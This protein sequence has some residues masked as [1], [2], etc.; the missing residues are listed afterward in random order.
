MKK[1]FY[2]MGFALMTVMALTLTS[3]GDDDDDLSNTTTTKEL[4]AV[5]KIKITVTGQ[6]DKF[7]W[8]AT[9]RG[10]VW[11]SNNTAEAAKIYDDK[12]NVFEYVENFS[13]AVGRTDKN[14][15]LMAAAMVI[16]DFDENNT[17]EITVKMEG[18]VDSKMTNSKTVVIKA[19]EQKAHALSFTTVPIDD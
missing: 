2:L 18:W 14:G 17:G 6:T 15:T 10:M 1:L 19:G 8:N 7:K 9:F 5:H 3:C 16:T 11:N 12:G 4:T 13:E